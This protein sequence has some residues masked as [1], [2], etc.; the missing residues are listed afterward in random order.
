MENG[1]LNKIEE[2]LDSKND[3]Y[4]AEVNSKLLDDF[5]SLHLAVNEGHL[6]I[7]EFLLDKG[8]NIEAKTKSGRTPLHLASI[9]GNYMI[10]KFLIDKNAFTNA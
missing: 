1:D 10:C 7:C 2:L 8:A 4:C 9:R 6:K 5:T 3:K